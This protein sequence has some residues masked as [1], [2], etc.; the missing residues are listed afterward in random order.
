MPKKKGGKVLLEFIGQD[1]RLLPPV[2]HS[3]GSRV[4]TLP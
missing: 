1:K 3:D 2:I 4:R